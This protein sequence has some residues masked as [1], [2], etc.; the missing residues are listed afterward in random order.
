M[1]W[2]TVEYLIRLG[3]TDDEIEETAIRLDNGMELPDE[4]KEDLYMLWY[5]VEEEKNQ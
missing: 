2:K 4:V 5:G 1:D 3:Y